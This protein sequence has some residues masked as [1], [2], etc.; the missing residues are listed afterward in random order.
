[1]TLARVR[2]VVCSLA[3]RPLLS[4]AIMV[5][6]LLVWL[7]VAPLFPDIIDTPLPML[8]SSVLLGTATYSVSIVALWVLAR[9]PAGPEA[10]LFERVLALVRSPLT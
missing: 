4:T 10:Y 1:M 3:W 5:S 2:N 8:L 7:S 6:V 9:K